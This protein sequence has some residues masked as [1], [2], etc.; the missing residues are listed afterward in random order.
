MSRFCGERDLA[1]T[2]SA[3]EHWKERSLL[4]GLSLFSDRPVWTVEAV[5]Q[6][7]QYFVENLDWGT[8]NFLQKLDSQ[9]TDASSDAKILAAEMMW[10][11]MLCPSN[12]GAA[13]K[14]TN[15]QEI[16]QWSGETLDAGNDLLSD[17]VLQGAGSAGTAFNNLR[18]KE[19][20]Y[21]IKIAQ[22]LFS[23][24]SEQRRELFSEGWKFCG[25]LESIPD[26]ERRQLRHMLLFIL[27]PDQFDRIFG[28]TDRVKVAQL[29]SDKNRKEILALTAR[30][31]D[32]LLA[33][34]RAKKENDYES[35]QIDWYFPPLRAFWQPTCVG[36]DSTDSFYSELQRFIAQSEEG[37]LATKDYPRSH[38]ELEVRV[39]FGQGNQAHVTW[40]AFLAEGQTPT[41]GIYPVYLFYKAKNILVLAKGISATNRPAEEWPGEEK[42]LINSYFQ[43]Q[44][45]EN[46]IRYGDSFIHAVYDLSESL[47][48]QEVDDDLAELIAQYKIV[49]LE[50]GDAV[51]E[52]SAPD[53]LEVNEPQPQ[54]VSI[55]PFT[56]ENAM[57]GLF[58][59]D[60]KVQQ[61]IA[62]L[63]SKKN[64]ILQGP[65]GVGK[66]FVSKRLA[67]ALMKAKDSDRLGMIQF[68]QSYSYEDFI[69]G[70]RPSGE[71]FQL[72]NGV[73]YQFCL[74][75]QQ[76]PDNAYVFI[77]DEINRGNLSKIF[78][79]LMMLIEHDKRGKDWA[80]PLTYADEGDEKFYV[81]ANLHL[82]GLMNTADRS[83]A[84]VDYALRRRF[85]F[86]DLVPEF[87]NG[88]FKGYMIERGADDG[89]V[90]RV[91]RKMTGLNEQIAQDKANLGP[92]FCIGHSFFTPAQGDIGPFDDDWYENIIRSEIDPLLRE[93]WFDDQAKAESL[94]ADL[95]A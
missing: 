16:Y 39:S 15:I 18:W 53:V 72:K 30:E 85:A 74:K 9:L 64:I 93:Y 59:Q 60:Q 1:S 23:L 12:I 4:Q 65:P 13:K 24:D 73:F 54:S 44:Y 50:E 76:D 62:T 83:L 88:K 71:G 11:M 29:F 19:L 77:I 55:E 70:F 86:I 87:T 49:A 78:G 61:I 22:A 63:K 82:V 52:Q 58:I 33:E 75:A 47:A 10:V 6:L 84:M 27:F 91:I 5:A 28:G 38:E 56:L 25:W 41:K 90:D 45:S 79:E 2:F 17:L 81:P 32:M 66:T 26:N 20:V 80:M 36:A 68:H 40:V 57:D 48:Q 67:Y 3:A 46:A 8:G 37:S 31:L 7:N 95:L 43:S 69:Q 51:D 94:V 34:L 92:G 89:L 21:F 35:D 42:V 14:V